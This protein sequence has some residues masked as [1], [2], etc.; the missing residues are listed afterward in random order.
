VRQ[1]RRQR[2]LQPDLRLVVTEPLTRKGGGFLRWGA[3]KLQ[4]LQARRLSARYRALRKQR[5]ERDRSVGIWAGTAATPAPWAPQPAATSA[6]WELVART[7]EPASPRTPNAVVS[8]QRRA[9]GGTRPGNS[10]PVYRVLPGT[11]RP[12]RELS[13]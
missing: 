11:R 9:L 2:G 1:G 6:P 10:R 7:P 4:S 8:R 13:D 3:E 5:A 12:V